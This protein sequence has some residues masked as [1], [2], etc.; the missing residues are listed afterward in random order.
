MQKIY[1]VKFSTQKETKMI[2]CTLCK[3]VFRKHGFYV[4]CANIWFYTLTHNVKGEQVTYVLL[5]FL[6]ER[7]ENISWVGVLFVQARRGGKTS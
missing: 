4:P 1:Y 7:E 6:G 3:I 2:L 5:V